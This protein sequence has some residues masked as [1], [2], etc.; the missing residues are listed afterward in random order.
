MQKMEVEISRKKAAAST[1][2]NLK[3]RSIRAHMDDGNQPLHPERDPILVLLEVMRDHRLNELE[4]FRRHEALVRRV[5]EIEK[6][7]NTAMALAQSSQSKFSLLDWA[8]LCEVRL[9]LVTAARM[10]EMLNDICEQREVATGRVRDPR[11][12]SVRTYPESVLS[13]F[14]G[15]VLNGEANL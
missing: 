6:K 14:F 8:R 5:E 13:E 9:D 7:A 11:F 3:G 1:P 12:G 15:N 10:A 4:Q 2:L